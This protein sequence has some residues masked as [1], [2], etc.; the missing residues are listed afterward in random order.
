MAHFWTGGWIAALV[1][2]VM[3]WGLI[4]WAAIFHRRRGNEIPAQT[5]YNIPIEILY[6]I[7]PFIIVAVFFYFT[8]RDQSE[9]TKISPDSTK[10]HVIKVNGIRW[11]WQFTYENLGPETAVTGTPGQ[12]PVL[13]LPAGE[14]VR[15]ELTSSD[16]NHS[17]WI[18]A[19]MMKMD[20]LA[21]VTNRFEVTPTKEGT[22]PGRCAELCGRNHSL[23][24]FTVKVVSPSEYQQQI[25]K[26]KGAMA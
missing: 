5:K 1:V 3:V 24:L 2:G 7:V 11:S 8:A 10:V 16:V 15:F 22:Y 21:G 19:F 17:F 6:T 25:S 14:R 12:P 4:I 23:M 26:L 9:I 20:N 13:Y 18:P